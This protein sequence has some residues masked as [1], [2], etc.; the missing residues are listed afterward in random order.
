MGGSSNGEGLFHIC[1]AVDDVD[2]EIKSLKARGAE[3]LEIPP[4]PSIPYKRGFIRRRSAKGVLIEL[5]P[6]ERLEA[7]VKAID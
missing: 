5:V 6:S 4:S 2:A 7:F 1:L 3:V